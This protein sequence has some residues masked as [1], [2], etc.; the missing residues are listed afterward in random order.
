MF[1]AYF[2]DFDFKTVLIMIEC[3][4]ILFRIEYE[5]SK[6]SKKVDGL[7]ALKEDSSGEG[8]AKTSEKTTYASVEV[9]DCSWQ[10]FRV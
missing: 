3:F 5:T 2:V 7:E 6:L 9:A 10:L 1:H 8:L 4:I